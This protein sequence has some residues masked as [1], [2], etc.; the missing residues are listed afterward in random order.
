MQFDLQ[1]VFFVNFDNLQ[2]K[3]KHIQQRNLAQ[4]VTQ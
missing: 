3:Q 4:T 1:F 2:P